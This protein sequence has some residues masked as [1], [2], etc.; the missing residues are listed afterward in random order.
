MSMRDTGLQLSFFVIFMSSLI[1]KYCWPNK[2]SWEVVLPF[3][4]QKEFAED[5][6]YSLNV[7]KNLLVK[8]LALGF[9]LF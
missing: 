4:Y 9:S 2:M 3:D 8:H 7:R 5:C 1:S 6:S